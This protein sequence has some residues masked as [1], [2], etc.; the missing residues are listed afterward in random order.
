VTP[1]EEPG[2]RSRDP[3]VANLLRWY[4]R[5]WRQRYGEEFLAMVE[6]GL[7]GQRPTWR[8]TVSVACAGLRER[9][10]AL[11]SGRALARYAR[12]IDSVLSRWGLSLTSAFVLAV[13]RGGR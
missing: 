9:G 5:A 8:L 13:Y 4:P 11:V 6:D 7:D 3:A 10:R 12:G 1:A 2:R